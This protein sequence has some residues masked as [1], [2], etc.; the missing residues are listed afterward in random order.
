MHASHATLPPTQP[1]GHQHVLRFASLHAPGRS[2][3]IPCDGQ[4]QVDLDSLSERMRLAYLGARA[5]IGREFGFPVL[6]LDP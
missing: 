3:V 6:E 1:P 2:I 5:L 4:G